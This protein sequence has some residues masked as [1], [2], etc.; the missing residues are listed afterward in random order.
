MYSRVI[1]DQTYTF[2][3][4]GK[5]IRNTLVMYDRQSDSLWSQLLGRAVAGPLAGKE[6][7]FVPA[8]HTTWDDWKARHPDTVAL[9]KGYSGGR[10]RYSG[11]YESGSAGVLGRRHQDDRLYVKEFVVGVA[12]EGD[13]RSA[14]V[15]FPFSV[16]N[17]EPVVNAAVG[18]TPVLVVFDAES[19][20]AAVYRRTLD[21][22]A[23]TFR[24]HEK[25]RMVDVET[26]T[27]WDRWSGEALSGPLAGETLDRIKSTA[28]F[29]F[30]W[31]DWYPD[32]DIY[33]GE[34][35]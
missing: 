7:E 2:G 33:Q 13:G 34:S 14:A 18:Q 21:A 29:W 35:S 16:L 23:F 1:D 5:L 15:A 20:A 4:S 27:V 25:N 22:Q 6:L 24:P 31:K 12:L 8:V 3:V 28:A 17:Q 19:G 10:D 30:G 11:Y 26:G 9:V 32:T